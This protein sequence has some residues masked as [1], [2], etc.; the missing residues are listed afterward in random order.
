MVS[1]TNHNILIVLVITLYLILYLVLCGETMNEQ[2][3]KRTVKKGSFG[4]NTARIVIDSKDLL[5]LVGKDV[6]ITVKEIE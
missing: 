2:K 4:G 1:E 3:F 5:Q 6:E